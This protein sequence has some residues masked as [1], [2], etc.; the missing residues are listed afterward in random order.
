MP[1]LAGQRQD[2]LEKVLQAYRKGD[3][4]SP[5]MDAMSSILTDEDIKGLAAHYAYQKGRPVVYV[6]VPNK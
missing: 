2:Y 5:E 3:R 1:A 6:T 4:K